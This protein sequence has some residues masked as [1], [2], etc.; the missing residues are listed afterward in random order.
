MYILHRWVALD[1]GVGARSRKVDWRKKTGRMGTGT[2]GIPDMLAALD[3][4]GLKMFSIYVGATI[5][6]D[7]PSYDA[8]LPTA[9]NQL[10]G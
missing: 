4:H 9:I 7:G 2:K 10:A 3:K 1:N 8:G 5:G 6:D